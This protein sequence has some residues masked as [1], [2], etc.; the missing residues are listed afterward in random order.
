MSI[1]PHMNSRLIT[2]VILAFAF[3]ILGCSTASV[4]VGNQRPKVRPEDVKIYLRQPKA[5]EEIALMQTDSMWSFAVGNQGRYNAVINRMKKRAAELGANGILLSTLGAETVDFGSQTQFHVNATAT[6]YGRA[7]TSGNGT[8][9]NG[10]TTATASGYS[11]TQNMT[12]IIANGGGM[13][14]WVKE[15]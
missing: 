8:T 10:T 6:T 13:A 11:T 1:F 7:T 15:E 9:Y 12:G 14:I 2:P 5:Y 4:V 3:T